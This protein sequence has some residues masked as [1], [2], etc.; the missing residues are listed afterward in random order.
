[1]KLAVGQVDVGSN[2]GVD[3]LAALAAGLFVDTP[4]ITEIVRLS[5]PVPA[6]H[7]LE[8]AQVAG[9]AP[10]RQR[11]FAAGRACARR[12]LG[13][14][15]VRDVVLRNGPDRAP[16]WPE[17]FVGAV[18][19]TGD[20]SR[21]LCA[22]AV[23]RRGEVETL[24]LDAELGALPEALWGSLLTE[25]ERAWIGSLRDDALRGQGALLVFSAK[26]SFYKAHFPLSGR[27]LEFDQV[28]IT[29]VPTAHTFEARLTRKA[30]AGLPL[31]QCAGRYAM[32]GDLLLT[33]ITV[34]RLG[35]EASAC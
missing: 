31:R 1:M 4:V 23:A 3:R 14:L 27:F 21:G 33:A 26:E 10:R 28:E 9:A 17:G 11:E 18:T 35:S 32:D 2:P 12:A 5:D 22:V 8:A 29:V 19:H 24:G 6:L 16:R 34:T 25:V 20:A 15:G 7:P 30:P 13:R